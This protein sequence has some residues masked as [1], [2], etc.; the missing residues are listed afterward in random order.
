MASISVMNT[1]YTIDVFWMSLGYLLGF[2]MALVSVK[3]LVFQ[4]VVEK[5]L[6]R[7]IFNSNKGNMFLRNLIDRNL[8]LQYL[9][10]KK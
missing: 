1:F 7:H 9:L 8:I 10:A 3:N 2:Y 4:S 6:E 5:K